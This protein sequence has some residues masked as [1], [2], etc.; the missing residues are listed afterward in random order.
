MEIEFLNKHLFLTAKPGVFLVNM[1]EKD[2]LRKKN[3]W[4]PKIKEWVDENANGEPI[5]PFSVTTEVGYGS[6]GEHF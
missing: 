5:I 1:S 6:R 2:Y 3:K 4:L